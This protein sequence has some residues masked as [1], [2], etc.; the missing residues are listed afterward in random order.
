MYKLE[1][2]VALGR[3]TGAQ[4]ESVEIGEVLVYSLYDTYYKIYLTISSTFTEELFYVDM[5]SLKDTYRTYA[6]TLNELLNDLNGTTLETVSELPNTTVKYAR[7]MNAMQAGYKINHCKIGY[8]YP[9]NYSKSDLPDLVLTRPEYT[10][11]MTLL[12]KYCLLTVNGY[13]HRSATDGTKAYVIDGGS[14]SMKHNDNHLG[15]YS[16]LDIGAKEEIRITEDMISGVD[17]LT[18]LK[19]RMYI[20]IPG[21]LTGKY[22]FLVIGGYLVLPQADVLWPVNDNLYAVNPS[23]LPLAERYME[24]KDSLDLSSLGV[25]IPS[26]SENAVSLP[27]FLSDDVLKKYFTLSQSFAVVLDATN[28]FIDSK[29]I[30]HSNLPGM[31]TTWEDPVYPLCAGHGRLLEYWKNRSEHGEVWSV[32]TNDA[33]Y[34]NYVF[35]Y[36]PKIHSDVITD[37]KTPNLPYYNDRGRLLVIGSYGS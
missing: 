17:E 11:D 9:S 5:D 33:F 2:A 3:S 31:F 6:K 34:R 30:K 37:H 25:T 32:T 20:N 7:Y 27:E 35:S 10:T 29:Y 12:N 22:V 36:K 8:N 4:W 18:P 28:I 1:S 23:M 19:K 15:I 26:Y 14:T 16:F 24:S 13:I 21:D